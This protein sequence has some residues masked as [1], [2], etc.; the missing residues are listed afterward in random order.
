MPH[1]DHLFPPVIL[2]DCMRVFITSNGVVRRDATMPLN[3]PA[4]YLSIPV[5]PAPLLLSPL[6]CIRCR[7]GKKIHP[8]TT[9]RHR[10][11]VHPV[12]RNLTPL[13]LTILV[14]LF[15]QTVACIVISSEGL[16]RM[17]VH[18]PATPPLTSH[19]TVWYCRLCSLL[20][21]NRFRVHSY[22]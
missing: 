18:T 6:S 13:S 3:S 9:S 12:Y 17:E 21:S 8:N 20:T 16:F 14:K 4:L 1:R 19:F 10:H 7:V 5:A 11:A 2:T 22:L 15:R